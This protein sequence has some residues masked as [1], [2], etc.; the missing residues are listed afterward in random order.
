MLGT[1]KQGGHEYLKAI[2]LADGVEK[3]FRLD[4]IREIRP[5]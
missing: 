1:V 4:R 3:L 5:E 2:C